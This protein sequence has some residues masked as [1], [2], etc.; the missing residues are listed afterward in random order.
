MS[1]RRGNWDLYTLPVDEQGKLIPG[2]EPTPITTDPSNEMLPVWSPWSDA[3][4][5]VSDRSGVWAVYIMRPDGSELRKVAD[6]GGTY[7]PP[8]WKPEVGGR[9][10]TNEQISWSK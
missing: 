7:D 3:V 2:A 8:L 6:I 1:Q 10:V 5:F 4:A 9:G